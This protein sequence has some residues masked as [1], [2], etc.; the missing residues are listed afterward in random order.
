M[1]RTHA[2]G[3]AHEVPFKTFEYVIENWENLRRTID[4]LKLRWGDDPMLPE[5]LDS[6]V[7]VRS[8]PDVDI[9]QV[10]VWMPDARTAQN[11]NR[12]LS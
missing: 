12:A 3:R 10:E 4:T 9:V 2:L 6:M 8:L 5:Q 1:A 11:V 7:S